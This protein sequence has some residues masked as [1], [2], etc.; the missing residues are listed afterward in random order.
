MGAPQVGLSS[1]AAPGRL[2]GILSV[3]P[4]VFFMNGAVDLAGPGAVVLSGEGVLCADAMT[5]P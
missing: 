5:C 4:A 2:A 1:G 3:P